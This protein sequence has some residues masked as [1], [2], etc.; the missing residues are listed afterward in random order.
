M[1]EESAVAAAAALQAFLVST[2]VCLDFFESDDIGFSSS[3][4]DLGRV[5][6]SVSMAACDLVVHPLRKRV[7]AG[8]EARFRITLTQRQEPDSCAA[9]SIEGVARVVRTDIELVSD[10]LASV[11]KFSVTHTAGGEVLVGS[12]DIVV[13]VPEDAALGSNVV[14]RRVIV[15]DCNVALGEVPVGVI[16]GFNH[17]PAPAGWVYSATAARDIHALMQALDEGCSTQET[18]GVSVKGCRYYSHSMTAFKLVCP[19]SSPGVVR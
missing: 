9:A 11:L 2:N 6:A 14:I 13:T 8:A 16:V 4:Q 19:V 5:T 1:D 18:T 17:E 15:A 12:V 7:Q 3:S 10:G